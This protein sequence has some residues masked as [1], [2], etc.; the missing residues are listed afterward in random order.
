MGRKSKKYT[1][2]HT[3]MGI[4]GGT[5]GTE[6]S[7]QCRRCKR[8]PVQSLAEKIPREKEMATHSNVPIFLPEKSHGQRSL[9]GYSP[10]GHKNQTRLS[11]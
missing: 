6:S 9:A 7:C 5:G 10:L 8:P 1:H 11:D 4:P 3:H 2:S